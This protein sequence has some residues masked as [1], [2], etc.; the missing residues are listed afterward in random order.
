MGILLFVEGEAAA[1][2]GAAG[3]GLGVGLGAA[4]VLADLAGQCRA[5]RVGPAEEARID[6]EI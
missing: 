2:V 4:G 1:F 6:R 3:L 5:G